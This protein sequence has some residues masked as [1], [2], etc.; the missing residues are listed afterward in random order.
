[1]GTD[2]RA[3]GCILGDSEDNEADYAGIT[4]VMVTPSVNNTKRE[5]KTEVGETILFAI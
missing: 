5:T 2:H 4:V 3:D 1:M